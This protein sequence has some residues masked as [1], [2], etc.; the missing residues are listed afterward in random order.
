MEQTVNAPCPT[1]GAEEGLR[2]RTHIDDIPYFGE[3]TQV[4]LLCVVCGWRQTDLIPAEAQTPTGWMLELSSPRHLTARVVRSTACTVRIPELDL[5]VAPGSSSTGYV[6]NVEGVLQRFL[7]V[8]D[9]VERDVVAH[10]DL[11]EER[12]ALDLLRMRLTMTMAGVFDTPVT[13]ELLDPSGRSLILDD[14]A[15]QREL[16]SEE[17]DA[18]PMG[19][20]PPVFSS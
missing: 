8:L 11:P 10:G 5:E 15:T 18:L 12:S 13:L 2:L 1:C 19:P 20:E 16:T 7:D 9:I 14:D 17:A 4:T 6:S 3:H